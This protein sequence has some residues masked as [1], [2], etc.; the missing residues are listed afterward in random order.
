MPRDVDVNLSRQMRIFDIFE[1]SVGIT[2]CI[3]VKT[4]S[5][6]VSTSRFLSMTSENMRIAY[7]KFSDNNGET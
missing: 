6:F 1:T 5:S 3:A 7:H 2:S 4:P